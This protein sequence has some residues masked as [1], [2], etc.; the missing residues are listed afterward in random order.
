LNS[1]TPTSLRSYG[2]YLPHFIPLIWLQYS[3][4]DPPLP[5]VVKSAIVFT[6]TLSARWLATIGRRIPLIARMI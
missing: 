5:A 6:G 1:S 2:I 4:S 3:V